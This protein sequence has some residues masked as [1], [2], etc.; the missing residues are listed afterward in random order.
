LSHPTFE[1]FGE[2]G[3][4]H[5]LFLEKEKRKWKTNMR[6]KNIS[7][8][9][10]L[11][12]LEILKMTNKIKELEGKINNILSLNNLKDKFDIKPIKE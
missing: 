10:R 5:K 4:S 6:N 2:E 7:K 1:Y 11:K 12:F 9:T 8:K 3:G